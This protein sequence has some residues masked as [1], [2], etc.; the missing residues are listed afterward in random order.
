MISPQGGHAVVVTDAQA[1]YLNTVK[2][3]L[4]DICKKTTV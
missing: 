3:G 1:K 2:L 4:K